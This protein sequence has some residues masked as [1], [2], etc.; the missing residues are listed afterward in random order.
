M[1][2][3]SQRFQ[4][5]RLLNSA[6]HWLVSSPQIRILATKTSESQ[7][8]AALMGDRTNTRNVYS[9]VILTVPWW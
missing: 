3:I 1:L 5:S 6:C 8:A 7:L 2:A 4:R 9:T